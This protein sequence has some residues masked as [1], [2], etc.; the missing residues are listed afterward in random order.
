MRGLPGGPVGHHGDLLDHAPRTRI[1]K[2]FQPIGD[3]ILSGSLGE[4]IHE[5]FER[6]DVRHRAETAQSGRAPRRLRHEVMDDSFRCNVVEWFTVAR[7]AA[8]GS[9]RDV[10]RRWNGRRIRQS[11]CSE[12]IGAATWPTLMGAAP[13][14]G[15]PIDGVTCVIHLGADLH[16]HRRA[17]R[18]EGELLLPS[19]AHADR[20]ARHPQRNHRGVGCGVVGAV[21]AVASR[22]LDMLNRDRRGI[23]LERA[24][25]RRAQR[26][27][28]LAMGP[29]CEMSVAIDRKTA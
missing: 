15:R 16:H 3:R 26:I 12:Q 21:M 8:A 6:K 17:D 22:P 23:E 11:L 25:E 20:P 10:D 13:D 4:F 7:G 18:F 1:G 5:R 28:S 29:Y 2:P 24:R 9:L 27:D 19:P 14:F